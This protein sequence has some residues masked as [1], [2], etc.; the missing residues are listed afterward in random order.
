M[1]ID[2]KL[3][4]GEEVIIN[5][6][7]KAAKY[8]DNIIYYVDEY[9]THVIDRNNRIYERRCPEDI[10]R[11]DFNNNLLTVIFENN[12]LKYDINTKYEEYL[13]FGGAGRAPKHDEI[14]VIEI[15]RKEEL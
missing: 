5:E 12:N 11:V 6:I 13:Y 10:F 1:K 2:W 3:K 4:N 8:E 7:D 15:T 9:G 14:K